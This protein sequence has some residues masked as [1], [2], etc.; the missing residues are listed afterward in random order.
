MKTRPGVPSGLGVAKGWWSSALT[1]V[2]KVTRFSLPGAAMR[3]EG[4]TRTWTSAARAGRARRRAAAIVRSQRLWRGMAGRIRWRRR[5][6]QLEGERVS[7]FSYR[8]WAVGYELSA[9]SFWRSA[10][11]IQV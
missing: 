10:F 4:S 3:A 9:I 1:M 5:M 11:G 7:A 2:G 8:L 6:R